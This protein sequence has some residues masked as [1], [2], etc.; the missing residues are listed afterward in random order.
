M[1][2]AL[3]EHDRGIIVIF[4]IIFLDFQTSHYHEQA[5]SLKIL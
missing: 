5:L 3:L 4:S 2:V 1:H